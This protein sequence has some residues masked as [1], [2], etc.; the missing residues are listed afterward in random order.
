MANNKIY[1]LDFNRSEL[2]LY[3]RLKVEKPLNI[4]WP[5]SPFCYFSTS[6]HLSTQALHRVI[7]CISQILQRS[8]DTSWASE[9]ERRWTH[10]IFVN[11]KNK[12]SRQSCGPTCINLFC[13]FFLDFY[14]IHSRNQN[15]HIA[16]IQPYFLNHWVWNTLFGI[17]YGMWTLIHGFGGNVN[18]NGDSV[19]CWVLNRLLSNP[20]CY[21]CYGIGSELPLPLWRV[22]YMGT[23]IGS[24]KPNPPNI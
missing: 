21:L 19:S 22:I 4:I 6:A 3:S 10:F 9:R 24:V 12:Q 23:W 16:P 15:S 5:S 18:K 11:E 14:F 2:L 7:S 17:V 13:P 8:I 20:T 1:R